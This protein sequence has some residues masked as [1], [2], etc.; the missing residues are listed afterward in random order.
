MLQVMSHLKEIPEGLEDPQA[1]EMLRDSHTAYTSGTSRAYDEVL[2]DV[3]NRIMVTASIGKADIGALLFW[4]RLRADTSWVR[5]LMTMRETEVRAVTA[6]AVSA[7]RDQSLTVPQAASEGRRALAALPGFKTGDALAS[8]LL[9]AAA[10]KR[11]A[12]YDRRARAGLEALGL[13]ISAKPGRYRRYME[14]VEALRST[15]NRHG[16]IWTA[17]DV[18]TALYWLGGPKSKLEVIAGLPR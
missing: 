10:P 17:R 14:L 7:A 18:D 16:H 15:A 4:K 8:A 6:K 5:D 3:A 13:T 9:L 1:W 12:V 2:E 11:M